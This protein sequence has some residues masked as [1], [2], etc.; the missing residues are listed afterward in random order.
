M[1]G[2]TAILL[3]LRADR[4]VASPAGVFLKVL[5]NEIPCDPLTIPLR[6]K[7][8]SQGLLVTDAAA[9][10]ERN[11]TSHAVLSACLWAE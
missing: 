9:P 1:I 4:Y 6:E 2:E 5:A 7:L 8:V 11:Q 10:A 3:D